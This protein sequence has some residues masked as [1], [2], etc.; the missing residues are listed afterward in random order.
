VTL[1]RSP[2]Q[3]RIDPASLV[4][5]RV[6]SPEL[7]AP[8]ARGI[9]NGKCPAC[10]APVYGFLDSSAEGSQHVQITCFGDPA[11]AF[12]FDATTGHIDNQPMAMG[13]VKP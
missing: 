4:P 7:L 1:L 11:H 6:D 3:A 9:H 13:E 10:Q 5:I 12:F 2:T 8:L